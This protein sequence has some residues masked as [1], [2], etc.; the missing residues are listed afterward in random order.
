MVQTFCRAERRK[1]FITFRL[2]PFWLLLLSSHLKAGAD[3]ATVPLALIST[4]AAVSQ[5]ILKAPD[6]IE[7]PDLSSLIPG[8]IKDPDAEPYNET[9]DGEKHWWI[10]DLLQQMRWVKAY[11]QRWY[12]Q[13]LFNE[14]LNQEF[15][16][17]L[18]EENTGDEA[19][20]IRIERVDLISLNQTHSDQHQY[21]R[22]ITDHTDFGLSNVREYLL[23]FCMA[24]NSNDHPSDPLLGSKTKGDQSSEKEEEEASHSVIETSP[25]FI[26]MILRNVELTDKQKVGSG[27]FGTVYTAIF[28]VKGE[29]KEAVKKY[30]VAA[31][32]ALVTQT[33]KETKEDF[34]KR[35][36]R[37]INHLAEELEF[38]VNCQSELIVQVIGGIIEN[39]MYIVM[40]LLPYKYPSFITKMPGKEGHLSFPQRLQAL[41]DAARA[42]AFIISQGYLLR[43][44]KATNAMLTAEFRI[45]LI[46]GGLAVERGLSRPWGKKPRYFAPEVETQPFDELTEVYS[47]GLLAMQTMTGETITDFESWIKE[48]VEDDP[49]FVLS[50]YLYHQLDSEGEIVRQVAKRELL[51]II[52][53]CYSIDRSARLPLAPLME[54]LSEIKDR[55]EAELTQSAETL[56]Q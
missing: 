24:S 35:K 9:V 19:G 47:W 8:V 29:E 20:I 10:A 21:T 43:D 11:I 3:A 14:N 5:P 44:L 6:P 18:S 33:S 54:Q 39:P 31:K 2:L 1:R 36:K 26:K 42:L 32:S 38:L 28:L 46:D 55:M 4:F 30:R 34:C 16:E 56:N 12:E 27:S 40:E 17:L 41:L 15:L 7:L 51:P 23:A 52:E 13:T 50:E 53:N 22:G 37:A 49:D 45:K 48:C 25:P